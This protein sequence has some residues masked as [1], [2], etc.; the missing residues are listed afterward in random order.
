M[1]INTIIFIGCIF[2]AR[3]ATV[4]QASPEK[5][6]IVLFFV[7]DMG[8]ADIGPFGDKY[9]TPHL[10]RM[11]SEGLKL[12]DFYV[13]SV[14]CTPSRS[15]LMTGCYAERI[16]MGGKVVFPSDKRGLNPSE[17]TIA[18]VL[19]KAGYVT[20]CFGKWHLGDQP[21]FLPA[22]QG[23]D[24]YEGIPYSN[25]M[26]SE[27]G[28]K[29][30]SKYPPLPYMKQDKVVAYIPDRESQAV[31]T[32]AISD[33]V[34]DFIKQH[35]DQP[36]FA[37]VP[38]SAVHVPHFATK[39]RTDAAGGEAFVAQITEI[40]QC[41]GR[42][43][44]LLKTLNLDKKTLIFFT[45]DNG[46]ASKTYS[47]P[48]R[49]GKFGPKYEGNMRMATLAWW[50]GKI[51]AGKVTSEIG[52]TADLLPTLATLAGGE[53]PNDRIIDGK[54]IADLLMCKDG[55]HSPHDVLYYGSEG[56][57]QGKWKLVTIREKGNFTQELY[58][59][60]KDIGEQT[61]LAAQEPERVKAMQSL[62]DAHVAE[63]KKNSRPAGFVENPKPVLPDPTGLPTLAD[64]RKQLGKAAVRP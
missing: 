37:Y 51:P 10:D 16:G 61:N 50:P 52:T 1:R 57:R 60:D 39:E 22:K 5:P 41:V 2:L 44:E 11:A 36:F 24:E 29:E 3:A 56:M 42:V 8:Y 58:D 49:G 13:S 27:S 55:Y 30:P 62:L 23:F 19:K 15:A 26:W 43:M 9:E 31:M 54:D 18:K 33:A 14:C 17:I 21:D 47:F 38:F 35:K 34:V 20:G 63:V 64:Y 46:G 12:A 48:L 40:D 28:K 6:N 7:D 53:V 32:D 4:A 25:D 45:N 59:L